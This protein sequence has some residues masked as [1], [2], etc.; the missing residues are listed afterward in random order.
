MAKVFRSGDSLV[1]VIPK[2][3]AERYHLAP[4]VQV[5]MDTNDEGILLKPIGVAPWFSIEWERA[6]DA[7]VEGYRP[8]LEFVREE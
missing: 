4:G 7:V 5:E 8:V 6:L 3:V 1:V 2:P